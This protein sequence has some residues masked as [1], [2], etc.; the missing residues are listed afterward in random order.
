VIS[1][2]LKERRN[3]IVFI[4]FFTVIFI[5]GLR[6]YLESPPYIMGDTAIFPF[7][8]PGLSNPSLTILYYLYLTLGE[9][10][11]I[12]LLNFLAF[13][14]GPISVYF[15][16]RREK[17]VIKRLVIPLIYT[18]N[19]FAV[20]FFADGDGEGILLIYSLQPI[21]FYLTYKMF[22]SQNFKYFIFLCITEVI[23]QIFFF[24]MFL[25]SFFFQLPLILISFRERKYFF[26]I[27]PILADLIGFLSE[28]SEEVLIYLEIVPKVLVSPSNNPSLG[29][30]L[31][32][33]IFSVLLLAFAMFTVFV[34]K[35]RYSLALLTSASFLL[36]IYA[37]I[38]NFHV[39]IPVIS[40]LLAAITTFQTKVYLLSFGLLD[41]SLIYLKDRQLI[42]PLLFLILIVLLPS[43]GALGVSTYSLFNIKP[44]PVPEWYYTLYNYLSRYNPHYVYA[45]GDSYSRCLSS[46]PG[47]NGFLSNMSFGPFDAVEFIV[48]TTN[49]NYSWLK[50]LG[51]FGPIRLYYNENYTGIVHYFNG[52][53]V[54]DYVITDNEIVVKGKP[55]FIVSIPYS[56]FWTNAK[57][58]GEYIELTSNISYNTLSPLK[59]ELYYFSLIF[60]T[61]PF[62]LFI[63]NEGVK[64]KVPSNGKFKGNRIRNKFS[65]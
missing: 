18:L 2:R 40:A 65:K 14:I 22:T 45:Y 51:D 30:F 21:V 37:Y 49:L 64:L 25:F 9:L 8:N 33:Q 47:F 62:L 10:N 36:L 11:T 12:K 38:E 19:P 16:V 24:Q 43:T 63:I 35:N 34:Y 46:L 27:Y 58:Y 17:S 13:I 3:D 55:P 39:Y 32:S 7:S 31:Y 52:S 48:T 4:I 60:L 42:I 61:L 41:L 29:L 59:G 57:P 53:P 1:V 50:L 6:N 26:F 56:N 28:V 54:K 5:I 15:I 23:G 44:S 20:S